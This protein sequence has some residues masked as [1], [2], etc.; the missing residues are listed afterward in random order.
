[1]LIVSG[2][3]LILAN[4]DIRHWRIKVLNEPLPRQ[5]KP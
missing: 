3:Y 2:M 4:E 1:V 5:D